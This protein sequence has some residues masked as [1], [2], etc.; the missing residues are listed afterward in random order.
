MMPR[1]P[2]SWK[3]SF[4][5]SPVYLAFVVFPYVVFF[6][7]S[8]IKLKIVESVLL[9]FCLKQCVIANFDNEIK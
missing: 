6:S 2:L 9:L 4:W 7:F 5:S 1:G 3:I 8:Q